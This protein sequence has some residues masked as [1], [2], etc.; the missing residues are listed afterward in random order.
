[1]VS[2]ERRNGYTQIHEDIGAIKEA[3]GTIKKSISDSHD[4][5]KKVLSELEGHKK[6]D[7]NLHNNLDDRLKN[8]EVIFTK[9]F[10]IAVVFV[11]LVGSKALEH[12]VPSLIKILPV[13]AGN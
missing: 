7:S 12:L 4:T 13:F 6:E 11:A 1:M 2:K 8:V 5:H 9:K 10:V 3:V